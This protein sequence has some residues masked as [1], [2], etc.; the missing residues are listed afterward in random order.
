MSRTGRRD[1]RRA[2]GRSTAVVG[3]ALLLT[4]PSA[5]AAPQPSAAADVFAGGGYDSNLFL[6]VAADPD[7]PTYRPYAGGFLRLA[8]AATLALAGDDLRLELRGSTDVRQTFG[9]GTLFIDEG[10]LTLIRPEVGP[11]DV[12][13]GLTGG[14]FDATI[15]DGLSFWSLGGSLEAAWRLFDRW[16]FT[17]SYRLLGR[18]FGA[19]ARIGVIRDLAQDAELRI[20]WAPRLASQIALSVGYVD[21]RSSLDPATAGAAGLTGQFERLWAG[22]DGAHVAASGVRLY[23]AA[24]AGAMRP[25]GQ[26]ADLQLGGAAAASLEIGGDIE[27]VLRYDGLVDRRSAGSAETSGFQHHVVTAGL[28]WRS[29]TG[30]QRRAR[31]AQAAPAQ[32]ERTPAVSGGRVRF[33]VR[34]PRARSVSVVGSWNDW[35]RGAAEQVLQPGP[36]PGSW[37]GQLV[38]QPGTYRFQF[39]EDGRAVRPPAAVRYA[40]DDFGGED[41]ILEIEPPR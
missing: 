27:A 41:G 4:S 30:P 7:S 39:V 11:F 5:G 24:W 19:P 2:L 21:L 23:V 20:A 35:A 22:L 25:D 1:A 16:R 9:S 26:P 13:L 33:T 8:P 10:Q 37:Q 31:E 12:R 29:R 18:W 32:A 34:A 14:R 40:P 28:Q 3:L 15:D 36:E 17:A 38:L 6:L